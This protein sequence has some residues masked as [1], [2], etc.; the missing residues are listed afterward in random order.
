MRSVAGCTL[1]FAG[2]W[3]QPGPSLGQQPL[4]R[5][6]TNRDK[7]HQLD[8]TTLPQEDRDLVLLGAQRPWHTSPARIVYANIAV[9]GVP[10]ADCSKEAII[11]FAT[12]APDN[13]EMDKKGLLYGVQ[14]HTSTTRVRDMPGYNSCALVVYAILKRAGCKWAKRTANAKRIYD[15]AYAQGWRPVETQTGGCLVAWNSRFEGKFS[16]IGKGEHRHANKK[17][18]VLYRHL[19]V[20]TG[21]WMSMDNSSFWSK[22]E[23]YITTRPIRYERP[24]FLCPVEQQN[25]ELKRSRKRHEK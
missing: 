10:K 14:T 7:G 13:F 8:L 19:G 18:G 24:M 9:V 2:L 3:L 1:I 4:D 15:M 20:T 25:T 17:G 22:P 12:K 16:R 23:A 5:A 21:S 11:Y 6:E